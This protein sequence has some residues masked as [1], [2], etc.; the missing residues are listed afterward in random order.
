MLPA[1][2]RCSVSFLVP[3]RLRPPP[4]SPVVRAAVAAATLPLSYLFTANI[5]SGRWS[6]QPALKNYND[7]RRGVIIQPSE[8]TGTRP[9]GADLEN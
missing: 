4:P 3:V 2:V 1:V 7:R 9:A 8:N 6:Y 5:L